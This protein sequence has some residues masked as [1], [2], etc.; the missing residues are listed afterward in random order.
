[1]L[2]ENE[3]CLNTLF[4]EGEIFGTWELVLTLY[5]VQLGEATFDNKNY[6]MFCYW[7]FL[8]YM[9]VFC[10]RYVNSLLV[11]C[12]HEDIDTLFRYWKMIIKKNNFVTIPSLMKSFL[13][14]VSA[15]HCSFH[16]EDFI[17]QGLH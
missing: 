3:R 10:E 13:R 12:I 17:T 15:S 4:L 1:M 11:G 9:D 16:R 14:R 8:V 2:F 7:S 5:N 6:F